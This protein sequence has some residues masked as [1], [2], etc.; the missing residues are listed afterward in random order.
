MAPRGLVA[1]DLDGTL[2]DAEG[3]FL[4][5][6]LAVVRAL[7]EAGYLLA[8]NTG[9]LA[10]GFALE[11]AR[12]LDPEGLHAYS[13]GGLVG[14]AL[15]EPRRLHPF[16]E[17]ATQRVYELLK[18]YRFPADVI[19]A[20]RVRLHLA[21]RPPPELSEHVARTGTPSFPA[22][23]EALLAHPPLTVWL[24]GIPLAAWR[25]AEGLLDGE[26]EAEVHGPFEGLVYVGLRPRGRDKGTA[27]LEL[28][29]LLAVPPSRV[30]MVGDGLNDRPALLRAGLGIAVGNAVPPVKEAAH[31][32]VAPHNSGGLW[33]AYEAIRARFG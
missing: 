26:L 24:A 2:L 33:E 29:E 17:R 4:E 10:A 12:R 6:A 14:T 5:D 16:S 11:A 32:V 20:S 25:E 7:R 21:G 31:V 18:R 8:V 23:P 27:L 22:P 13:D 30:A 1:F 28:A 15:G 9:R 19:T 3:R